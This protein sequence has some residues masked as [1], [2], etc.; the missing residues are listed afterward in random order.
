[1]YMWDR[2]FKSVEEIEDFIALQRLI[3]DEMARYDEECGEVVSYNQGYCPLPNFG[4]WRDKQFGIRLWSL[5]VRKRDRHRCRR[6][7]CGRTKNLHAHHIYN[8]A[9]NPDL[10]FEEWNGVTLCQSCHILFH[11]IYG[12]VENDEDQIREFISNGGEAIA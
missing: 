6:E 11:K 9:D 10:R 4:D 8:Q 3:D 2:S 12:K 5:K 7:G 1:M